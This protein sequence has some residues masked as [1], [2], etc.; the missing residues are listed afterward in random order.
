MFF[1][2]I[3]VSYLVFEPEPETHLFRNTFFGISR[4]FPKTFSTNI[5]SGITE[6]ASRDKYLKHF[7]KMIDYEIVDLSPHI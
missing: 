3:M 4:M 6:F 1:L 5:L 7:N 2:S